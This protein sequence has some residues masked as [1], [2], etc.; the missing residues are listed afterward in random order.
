LSPAISAE[1]PAFSEPPTSE[2]EKV[3]LDRQRRADDAGVLAILEGLVVE[4]K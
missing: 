3:L 2:A 1:V 4:A